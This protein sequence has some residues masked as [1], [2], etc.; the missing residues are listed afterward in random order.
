M[1]KWNYK[2]FEQIGFNESVNYVQ[3]NK[4]PTEVKCT[5]YLYEEDFPT[6]VDEVGKDII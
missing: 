4:K 3:N 1:Y 6:I 2:Y 5:K